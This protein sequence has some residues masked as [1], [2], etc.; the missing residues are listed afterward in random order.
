MELVVLCINSF[1]LHLSYSEAT[2]YE[3]RL[4]LFI[5][6]MLVFGLTACQKKVSSTPTT[7]ETP[8]NSVKTVTNEANIT[9]KEHIQREAPP[10]ILI[11]ES[12]SH[13]PVFEGNNEIKELSPVVLFKRLAHEKIWRNFITCSGCEGEYVKVVVNLTNTGLIKNFR[14][15][16]TSGFS[17]L[18]DAA[19][20]AITNAEPFPIPNLPEKELRKAKVLVVNFAPKK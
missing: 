6:V 9:R 19:L 12:N 2:L 16:E 13:L 18:E 20:R 5:I 8:S 4:K 10:S 15:S 17:T 7:K 1:R 11:K 3:A 14:I